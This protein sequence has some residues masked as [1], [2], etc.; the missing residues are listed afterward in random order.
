MQQTNVE[1]GDISLADFLFPVLAVLVLPSQTWQT[2]NRTLLLSMMMI[3]V[4]V[5]K[6]VIW[7]V[8]L[9]KTLNVLMAFLMHSR[10]LMGT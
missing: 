4:L 2:L 10:Q 5:P 1:K 7:A 6:V 9:M 8:Y 3:G